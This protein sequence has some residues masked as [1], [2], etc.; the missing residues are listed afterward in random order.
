[1]AR[2]RSACWWRW[3]Q[4]TV[5]AAASSGIS[6]LTETRTLAAATLTSTALRGTPLETATTRAM[7]LVAAPSKLLRSPL[8]TKAAVS[9]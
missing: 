3:P 5:V 9:R 1:M 2:G 6:M 7:A 8:A 4:L